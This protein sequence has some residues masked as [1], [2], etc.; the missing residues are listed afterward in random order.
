MAVAFL[1][2]TALLVIAPVIAAVLVSVASRREDRAWSLAGQA[3]GK[4]ALIARRILAFH[5]RGIGWLQH[6]GGH[7]R[8]RLPESCS[9]VRATPE[10]PE[11]YTKES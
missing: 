11:G 7:G 10:D 6:A 2:F 9:L 5:A 1:I 4:K 3:P 8:S